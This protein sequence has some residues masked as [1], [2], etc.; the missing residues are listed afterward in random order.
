MLEFKDGGYIWNVSQPLLW[1]DLVLSIILIGVSLFLLLKILKRRF[2]IAYFVVLYVV[3]IITWFFGLHFAWSLTLVA[4]IVGCIVFLTANMG[5]IRTHVANSLASK[6][7]LGAIK[8][9]DIGPVF[10]RRALYRKVSD[11]VVSLS[12]QKIGAIITFEKNTKLD[13]VIKTGTLVNA[14][15]SAELLM[16]IFYPG[17]RLHDGA[18]V[19]RRD[20]I[21]AASVYYTPTT[22]P[23][24]GK[25]G[26]RHRAAIG[27][28]EIS[29]SVT[30]VVSEE[31]GRISLAVAGELIPTT[32]DNFL[33][34]FEDYMLQ[35]E[36]EEEKESH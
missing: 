21:V 14:P 22:K 9:K 17:T 1:V 26:S 2:A 20:E 18:V 31:T 25:Y 28:S 19:I 10:D 27:V 34:I 3:L 5:V 32:L 12:K 30:I 4:L 15:L 33:R 16:T 7:A 13:D 23:L 36:Q 6:A 24:T 35:E 29:D 11:A 8:S